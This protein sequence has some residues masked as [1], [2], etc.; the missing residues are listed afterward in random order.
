MMQGRGISAC[1]VS[2]LAFIIGACKCACGM[3]VY[4]Q[5]MPPSYNVSSRRQAT[6]MSAFDETCKTIPSKFWQTE[7]TRTPQ[8]TR[9]PAFPDADRPR[10]GRMGGV[11]RGRAVSGVRGA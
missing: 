8:E 3:D 10:A 1:H 5:L 2:T 9:I 7:T 4:C 6:A 11:P